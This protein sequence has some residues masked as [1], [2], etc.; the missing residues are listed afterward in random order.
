MGTSK[1][2]KMGGVGDFSQLPMAEQ[3]N[4]QDL[5]VI[6]QGG[7]EKAVEAAALTQANNLD[8]WY[9]FEMTIG[10]T[11]TT[12]V[13]IGRDDL[14]VS[15]PCTAAIYP[16]MVAEDK[17]EAYQLSKSDLTKKANGTPAV[18]TGA[19]GDGVAIIPDYYIDK[20]VD[21]NILRVKV[22][23]LPLPGF[24][25]IAKHGKGLWMASEDGNGKLR[26]ISGVKP[27][28]NK[29]RDYFRQKAAAKGVGWC[30]EPYHLREAD[31]F[32]AVTELLNLN[33]Q[34]AL[35][36]GATN[37]SGTDW[38]NYNGYNPVWNNGEG[39]EAD[40]RNGQIPVSV[41]NFVGGSAPL[42]TNI[43]VLWWMRDVFGHLYEW[44]DGINILNS[45]VGG[46]IAYICK[47]PGLFADNTAENYE[48][49]AQL[50]EADGY[51]SK[52][53]PGTILPAQGQ[54]AGS[55]SQHVG[56]YYYTEFD[57][58]PD[59]GWRVALWGGDLNAG[60]H[61]GLCCAYSLYSSGSVYARLGARLCLIF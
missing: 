7:E 12:V 61:A 51:I 45:S 60:S 5:L 39:N 34:E 55:S 21:G 20:K 44:V 9:G 23:P 16:A 31:F 58:S 49:Y 28:T 6:N 27:L 26:S 36:V 18:L 53:V 22:S 47:N 15:K 25:K 54:P 37:A 50:A 35:G 11:G 32:L 41:E 56:D 17:T 52:F 29:T 19:D 40:V 8:Y 14:K 57:T 30:I 3:V 46:S 13:A 38:S 33:S 48:E 43:A 24:I 42:S 1:V 59:G 10:Q 4:D 2:L